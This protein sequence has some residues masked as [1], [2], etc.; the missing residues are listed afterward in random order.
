MCSTTRPIGRTMSR[1]TAKKSIAAVASDTTS[2]VTRMRSP[3]SIIAVRSGHSCSVTS[4]SLCA[5]WRVRPMTRMMR[6]WSAM[7]T[8]SALRISVIWSVSRRSKVSCTGS[9]IG[10]SRT[11][12]RTSSRLSTTLRTSAVARSSLLRSGVT[13]SSGVASRARAASCAISRRFCR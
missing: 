1:C 7:K 10:L 11:S 8:R 3:W 12:S 2:E 5:P 13:V 9:G 6:S 4:I